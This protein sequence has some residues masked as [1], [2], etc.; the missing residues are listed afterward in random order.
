LK[1]R[2]REQPWFQGLSGDFTGLLT[3][4]PAERMD[5]IKAVFDFP[6][7]LA[8][9]PL[10]VLGRLRVPALWVL[11]GEDTEAPHE[12]TLARLRDLQAEGTP[13]DIAVFPH[14]DHGMIV[15]EHGSEGRRLAGR[16]AQGYFALLRDW[17]IGRKIR[18]DA[19]YGDAIVYERR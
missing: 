15:V 16:H 14:A 6:Y 4:T 5:E 3:A 19:R 2:Y 12:T 10:P 13:I 8:Y 17:I 7:D 11:A 9:E 1:A 18:A